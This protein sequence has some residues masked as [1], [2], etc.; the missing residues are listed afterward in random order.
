MY[1]APILANRYF[2]KDR[3][4]ADVKS[5]VDKGDL[6]GV[7][8]AFNDRMR[9]WYFDPVRYFT[10]RMRRIQRFPRIAKVLRW[11]DP[12]HF[13]FDVLAVDCL[14]VDALS[15]YVSGNLSAARGIFMQFLR[16]HLPR[17]SGSLD[18][19]LGTTGTTITHYDHG[20]NSGGKTLTKVEEVI[21]YGFR[22]GIVHQAHAPLYCSVDPGGPRVAVLPS[23]PATY[24]PSASGALGGSPCPT[25]VVNPWLFFDDLEAFFQTYLAKLKARDAVLLGHFKSKFTDSFGIDLSP[26]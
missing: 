18:S 4:Y 22:C 12:G 17:F 10:A 25:V 16:D 13:A 15:Q 7:V 23:G 8:D 6:A 5:L 14:L 2:T 21:Y 20:Q 9:G 19:I 1:Y 24:G 3:S 11:E 26:L